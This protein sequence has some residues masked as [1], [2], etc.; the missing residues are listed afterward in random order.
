MKIK[1]NENKRNVS[2]ILFIHF[3]NIIRNLIK[4]MQEKNYQQLCAYKIEVSQL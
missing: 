4:N 1:G 3:F 2:Q